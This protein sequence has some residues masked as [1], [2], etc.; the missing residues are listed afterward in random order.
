MRAALLQVAVSD[1]RHGCGIVPLSKC[2]G[3]DMIDERWLE[4]WKTLMVERSPSPA[5]LELGCGS[6][7][8]TRW[9]VSQG[10]ADVTA[11]DVSFDALAECARAVPSAH[12]VCHDLREPL[13]FSAAQFDVVLASLCLHYFTWDKTQ[14]IVSEIRRCLSADGMLLCRLNSTRDVHHGAVGHPEIAPHYYDVEGSP[15]RFFDEADVERLFDGGWNRLS[16]REATIDR[17]E[18]SKTVWEIVLRKR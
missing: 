12:L 13:P 15:K 4:G 14:E 6:G 7:L 16:I 2:I 11:V 5:I 17:Y 9:L 18:K 10:F 3:T 1:T 8:D